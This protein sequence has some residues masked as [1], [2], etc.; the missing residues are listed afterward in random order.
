MTLCQQYVVKCF[1]TSLFGLPSA[2][3]LQFRGTC[4]VRLGCDF[5]PLLLRF[6]TLGRTLSLNPVLAC[7]VRF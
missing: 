5:Q 2:K 4:G 1:S 6:G 7:L 3:G